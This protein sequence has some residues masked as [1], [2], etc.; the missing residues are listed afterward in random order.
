MSKRREIGDAAGRLARRAASGDVAAARAL[1]RLLESKS[2]EAT[3]II[4]LR[5]HEAH[6]AVVAVRFRHP[7]GWTKGEVL[8]AAYAAVREF[9]ET[10][11]GQTRVMKAGL[12]FNWGDALDIPEEAWASKGLAINEV[13]SSDVVVDH[14]ERLTDDFESGHDEDCPG[15]YG[16]PC[17]GSCRAGDHED[18]DGVELSD[19]GV[20]ER[21]DDDGTIRY[22][23]AHGNCEDVRRPGDAGWQEW[24]D[25][26]G[27]RESDFLLTGDLDECSCVDGDP[28]DGFDPNCQVHGSP[29]G[30]EG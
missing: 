29:E 25:L 9:L 19:G 23:D 13:I 20:I 8:D 10:D 26:F 16:G 14:D 17:G 28:D 11:E 22:R 15:R 24:A 2:G 3:T 27:V 12:D 5:T 4:G 6:G 1:L 21:P 18:D 7:S 30:D